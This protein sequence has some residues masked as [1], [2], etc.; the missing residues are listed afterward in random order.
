VE[1][2]VEEVDFAVEVDGFRETAAHFAWDGGW[3]VMIEL[4]N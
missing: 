2:E 3:Q 1:I 4:G